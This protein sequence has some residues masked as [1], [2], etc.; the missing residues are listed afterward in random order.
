MPFRHRYAIGNMTDVQA[1]FLALQEVSGI[2]MPIVASIPRNGPR[3]LSQIW[4]LLSMSC[5]DLRTTSE[6]RCCLDW[7][8]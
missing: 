5:F 4:R 2:Q 6:L 7:M 3:N 1:T 8:A